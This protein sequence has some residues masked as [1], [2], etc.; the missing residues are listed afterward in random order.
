MLMVCAHVCPFPQTVG[1]ECRGV[2][3]WFLGHKVALD[4]VFKGQ[5]EMK[6]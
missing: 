3:E 5:I 6:L 1:I 4:M 2:S